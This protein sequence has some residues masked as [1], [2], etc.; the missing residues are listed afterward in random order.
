F[1]YLLENWDET[2]DTMLELQVGVALQSIKLREWDKA[3]AAVNRLVADYND[4]PNIAKGLFQIGEEYF[5]A[6]EDRRAADL[7]ELVRDKYPSKE[8]FN[9]RELP[10]M[11]GTC[12]KNLG[13]PNS[14]I[15]YFTEAYEK[16]PNC[17]YSYRL[18]YEIAQ[19]CRSQSVGR[20]EE[21]VRW[22]SRQRK[23]PDEDN[24]AARYN[25]RA[26]YME[27]VVYLNK[28]KDYNK[29]MELFEQY[30]AE[31]P[32]GGSA[33]LIPLNLAIC[34]EALGDTAKAFSLVQEGLQK[35]PEGD[36]VE[37]YRRK[38]AQLQ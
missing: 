16:T 8:Y 10:Y 25:E 26:L 4:H 2:A 33:E 12:Y 19:I 11:L 37:S 13:D 5:Y 34:H 6:K 27:G 28:F 7:F 21:A 35:W 15:A 3:D 24:D 9:K 23:L 29:A 38:L 20:Y 22:Y 1:A 36:F 14:A 32:T 31:Y 17:Q 30:Q 18:C